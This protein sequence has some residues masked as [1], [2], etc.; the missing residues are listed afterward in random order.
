MRSGRIRSCRRADGGARSVRRWA[1]CPRCCR[2]APGTRAPAWAPCR[3]LA[4]TQMRSSPSLASMRP[5]C[6]R[7]ARRRQSEMSGQFPSSPGL[8]PTE[9]AQARTYLF[10][11]GNRPER[12]GKALASGADAV[13]LDLEDAVAVD[14]KADARAAVNAWAAAADPN[15]RARAV[16]RINETGS[17]EHAADLQLIAETGLP[18]VMLPKAE[19]VDQ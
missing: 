6:T 14:A 7:C 16:V 1:R 10:V 9:A 12:F 2:R 3:R 13:V 19:T 5:A 4:R 8:L 18:E 11:P 17:P 15:D